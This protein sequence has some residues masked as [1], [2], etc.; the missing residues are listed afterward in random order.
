MGFIIS[1]ELLSRKVMRVRRT[2]SVIKD[3]S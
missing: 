2:Y 1:R 3:S